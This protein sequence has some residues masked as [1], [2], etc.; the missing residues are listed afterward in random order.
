MAVISLNNSKAN[1][2]LLTQ[3]PILGRH[4]IIPDLKQYD[5]LTE[6]KYKM[7]A[8]ITESDVLFYRLRNS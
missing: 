7:Y 2:I 6:A 3:V 5:F 8:E 4:L 1:V